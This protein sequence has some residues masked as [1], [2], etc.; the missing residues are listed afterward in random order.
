MQITRI[1]DYQVL[2]WKWYSGGFGVI[3]YVAVLSR[4][5]V[6]KVYIGTTSQ[7]ENETESILNIAQLGSKVEEEVAKAVFGK[8]SIFEDDWTYDK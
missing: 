1:G 6:W 2:G 4:P 8:M 3:G 7:F 5:K